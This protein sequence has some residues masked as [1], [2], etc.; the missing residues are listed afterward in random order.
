MYCNTAVFE[1]KM[2]AKITVNDK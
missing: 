2:S 1:Y